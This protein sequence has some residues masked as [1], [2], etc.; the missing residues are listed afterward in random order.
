MISH[1]TPP[2]RCVCG[3]AIWQAG[4]LMC[5]WCERDQRPEDSRRAAPPIGTL[6]WPVKVA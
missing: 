3:A 2:N 5:R 1:S 6:T 4:Q